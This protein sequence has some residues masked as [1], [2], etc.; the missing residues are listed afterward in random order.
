MLWAAPSYAWLLLLLIPAAGYTYRACLRRKR[1]LQRLG[2]GNVQANGPLMVRVICLSAAFVLLVGALCRPQ[3]GTV[4]EEQ[5]MKGIDII[6][7]LDTSRSML[8]DDLPPT[9][10]AAAKKAIA[11]LAGRLQGDRIGLIAFA[12][13]AFTI[14]P[15][16]SDYTAFRQVLDEAGPDTIPKGGSDLSSVPAEV[17][18]G[19]SGSDPRSRLLILVSDGEDHSGSTA[20]AARLLERRGI[21]TCSVIAGSETGAII[22]LPGGGFL[23]DRHGAIVRSRANPA[24]LALFSRWNIRLDQSGTALGRIYDQAQSLLQ[25]RAVKGSRQRLAERFQIPLAGA[26][27]LLLIEALFIARR[28]P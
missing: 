21:L 1:D 15:L 22:P 4:I 25:Q 18:C 14:C 7:A 8:A 26:L 3:W 17:L 11:T 13:S 6:V 10:L 12:G 28:Q 20:E 9:R 2:A 5:E 27:I 23:K 16:T 19:F 24:A